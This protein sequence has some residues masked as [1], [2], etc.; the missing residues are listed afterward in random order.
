MMEAVIG[1]SNVLCYSY[2]MIILREILSLFLLLS[3][4]RSFINTEGICKN[5]TQ[6]SSVQSNYRL[7]LQ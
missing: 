7:L 5:M 6:Q 2:T 4:F 3:K 1:L